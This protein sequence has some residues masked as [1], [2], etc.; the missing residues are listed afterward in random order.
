MTSHNETTIILERPQLAARFEIIRILG[1]GAA[2]VVY[3]AKDKKNGGQEVALK[4]LANEN[5]F[6]EHTI[7]RFREELR[8][9]HEIRHPN[10]VEA[11]EL[12]HLDNSL[13]FSMEY[14]QGSDLAGIFRKRKFTPNQID[15]MFDQLLSALEELHSH[16]VLHRDIKLENILLREDGVVKL[17]DLGLMKQ[18]QKELTAT[19]VILGTA[20]YLPPEYVREGK[21][22]ARSEIYVLG[23]MLFELVTGKRWLKNLNGAKAIEHLIRTNFAFPLESLME[24]EK[25]HR[26]ILER[27]VCYKASD[28]FQSVAEMRKAFAGLAENFKQAGERETLEP[29]IM[30]NNQM[31]S[32]SERRKLHPIIR[33]FMFVIWI[34]LLVVVGIYLKK[35]FDQFGYLFDPKRYF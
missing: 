3:Q 7:E 4:V 8:V 32:E 33:A 18:Y 19:G 9:C 1:D 21:Y 6:D 26:R 11:Y 23:T 31:G 27:A 29:R 24:V 10:I 2:G 14:V 22:D 15:L 12:V 35:Q 20:H 17:S 13:A 25:K 30:L 16:G 28:R 34:A 5:A